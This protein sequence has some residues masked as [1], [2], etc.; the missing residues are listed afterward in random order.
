MLSIFTNPR[1]IIGWIVQAFVLLH[2]ITQSQ[3]T[4]DIRL[5]DPWA[6]QSDRGAWLLWF[7]DKDI[8]SL[9]CWLTTER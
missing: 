3:D 5:Q 2:K 6:P 8:R 1:L 4:S 7:R 9:S